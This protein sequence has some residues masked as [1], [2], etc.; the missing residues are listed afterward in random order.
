MKAGILEPE[1]TFI[2]RQW[3][4]KHVPRAINTQATMD[5]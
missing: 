5:Y 3:L 1:E 4:G 2:D